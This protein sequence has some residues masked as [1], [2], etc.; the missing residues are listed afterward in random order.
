[1]GGVASP[2]EQSASELSLAGTA[3][4]DFPEPWLTFDKINRDS[5]AVLAGDVVQCLYYPIYIIGSH[6]RIDRERNRSIEALFRI[7][8]L[9]GAISEFVLIERVQM[10]GDE[11]DRGP[12]T[13]LP[14][15]LNHTI[16]IDPER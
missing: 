4:Q 3:S 14:Q 6:G 9:P 2:R 7:R 10:E 11:V 16:A 5:S 15:L 13:A 8:E 1:M 12:D